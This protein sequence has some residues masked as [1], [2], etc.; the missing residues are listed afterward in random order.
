MAQATINKSVNI[1]N[2]K[3]K[4]EYHFVDTYVAGVVLT[5][6]EIKS[7]RQGKVNFLDAYCLF[8]NNELFMVNLNISAYER[9]THY[10]HLP[11]RERKLLLKKRELKRLQAKIEQKGLTI[12]PIRIFTSERGMAKIE[13][14]LAE[15]KKLYDKRE[16]IKQRDNDRAI[17]KGNDE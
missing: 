11:D 3:A 2:R 10:N 17:R 1:L 13:I 4:F 12:V 7:I 5:G 16:T 15:G 9:G 14:A 8:K 6:T